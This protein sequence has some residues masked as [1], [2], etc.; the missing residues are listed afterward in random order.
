MVA[1]RAPPSRDNVDAPHPDVKRRVPSGAPIGAAIGV[2]IP[3]AD[4]QRSAPFPHQPGADRNGLRRAATPVSCRACGSL[5]RPAT[6]WWRSSAARSKPCARPF[7]S[8]KILNS[9]LRREAATQATGLA[10][11]L[12]L[13]RAKR[14]QSSGT[15]TPHFHRPQLPPLSPGKFSTETVDKSA[16]IR[17]R[18]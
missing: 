1:R 4:K 17:W 6:A 7:Q 14:S 8:G 16:L 3:V 11:Q 10:R 9:A 18:R 5:A 12:R 15:A 2:M 13:P